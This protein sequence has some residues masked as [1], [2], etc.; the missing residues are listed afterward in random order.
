MNQGWKIDH[1]YKQQLDKY[2]GTDGYRSTDIY[3]LENPNKSYM[4]EKS[5]AVEFLDELKQ[6]YIDEVDMI[7]DFGRTINDL[8]DAI[9]TGEFS[10]NGTM[11]LLIFMGAEKV[12]GEED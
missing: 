6:K 4:F 7:N 9:E 10:T 12:E 2:L 5:T 8:F 3:I 11:D 1:Y